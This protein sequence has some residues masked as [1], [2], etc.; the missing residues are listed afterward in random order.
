MQN[1]CRANIR[2]FLL[3]V[4]YEK[5]LELTFESFWQTSSDTRAA[6]SESLANYTKNWHT[7]GSIAQ[8]AACYSVL[9]RVAACCSVLQCVAVC[10]S[11]LQCAVG[12]CS[13]LQ[14]CAVCCSVL[15]CV[16]A[17]CSVLQCVAVCHPARTR[18]NQKNCHTSGSISQIAKC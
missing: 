11:V 5:T 13:V 16:A 3:N 9:Q 1:D 17:C 15:Q 4:L 18:L 14:C 6:E 2:E 10:C 12:C 8:V 7:S